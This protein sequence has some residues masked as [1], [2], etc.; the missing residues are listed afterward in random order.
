MF[1]E[2][3]I[4]EPDEF[5]DLL[6]NLNVDLELILW[7]SFGL[8]AFFTFNFFLFRAQEKARS[9]ST[10]T[11]EL[12]KK[13][14]IGFL[15]NL[16]ATTTALRMTSLFY[17]FYIMVITL[18]LTNNIKTN[19]VV[20]LSG[21]CIRKLIGKPE[22]RSFS[23]RSWIPAIS[24]RPKTRSSKRSESHGEDLACVFK[25]ASQIIIDSFNFSFLEHETEQ[26]IA[27]LFKGSILNKVRVE[28][29]DSSGF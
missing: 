5:Y 12:L 24:S 9:R 26:K 23:S 8:L 15:N 1:E 17:E 16:I 2:L 19:K 4:G 21:F 22:K 28:P 10:G 11:F 29:L 3:P 13:F 18:L 7:F 14:V 27:E 25:Q 20:I 6:S